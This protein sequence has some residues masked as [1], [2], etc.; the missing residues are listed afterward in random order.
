MSR[1]RI[2]LPERFLSSWKTRRG[3]L[4]ESHFLAVPSYYHAGRPAIPGQL[5]RADDRFASLFADAHR[6][7]GTSLGN[8]PDDHGG[9][10]FSG[11]V[12]E[13]RQM[14][15]APPSSPC[16]PWRT[17]SRH[18][19]RRWLILFRSC[20]ISQ[21]LHKMTRT[22][23]SSVLQADDAG[24]VHLCLCPWRSE[25]PPLNQIQNYLGLGYPTP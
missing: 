7:G 10:W 16:V 2:H 1:A 24:A 18:S 23:P 11:E 15:L 6:P 4:S 5:P 22:R 17:E 12:R 14:Y 9:M 19:S 13:A 8:R 25:H 21:T 20:R 3:R